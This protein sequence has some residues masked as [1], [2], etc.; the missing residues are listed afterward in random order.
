MGRSSAEGKEPFQC[1]ISPLITSLEPSAVCELLAAFD[2]GTYML[3]TPVFSI[4]VENFIYS[5]FFS[6]S[7]FLFGVNLEAF[8]TFFVIVKNIFGGEVKISSKPY[9]KILRKL[10]WANMKL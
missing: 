7:S 10:P 5:V 6:L 8:P 3:Q 1:P 4:F 9:Y 2:R